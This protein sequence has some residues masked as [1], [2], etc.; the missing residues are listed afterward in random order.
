MEYAHV[1]N[2]DSLLSHGNKEL[3]K[4]VLDIIDAGLKVC[5]SYSQVKKLVRL[6]GDKLSVGE[7]VYDLK[8]HRRIYVLGAGKATFPMAKALDDILGDGITDGVVICKHGQEG[9]LSHSRLYFASHPIPDQYGIDATQQMMAIARQ[10]QKDDLIFSISSGGST[11]LMPY[12]VEGITLEDKQQT[13]RVLLHS[14][15]DIFEMNAVRNH[16]TRSKSGWLAKTIHPEAHIFNLGISDAVGLGEE[17]VEPCIVIPCTFNDARATL[18][19]YKL[20]DSVPKSVADYIRNGSEANENPQDLSDHIIYNYVLVNEDIACQGALEKAK[21]LGFNAVILSTM[22]ECDAWEMGVMY[23]NIAREI[24]MN[25]RPIKKPAVFISGGENVMKI[26]IPDPGLGGPSQQF[27]LSAA[28]LL[29]KIPGA[30]VAG[31]DTDG[32]DGPTDMAGGIADFTTIKKAAELGIDIF[33]YLDNF[34]ATTALKALGAVIYTG[35]TGTNVND[36][37]VVAVG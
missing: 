7:R 5:D 11:S 33:E 21:E 34:D 28:T 3:K 23:A 13:F 6:N 1:R 2:R 31:I 8:K 14:G 16:L 30:V 25:D 29:A 36:L 10:T 17:I 12:P 35:A 4:A 9:E 26:R 32:T 20:W 15:A 19:K 27:T 18:T 22:M 24:Y 37:R